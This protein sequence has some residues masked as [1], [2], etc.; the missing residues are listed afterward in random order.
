MARPPDGRVSSGLRKHMMAQKACPGNRSKRVRKSGRS[1]LAWLVGVPLVGFHMGLLAQR[2]LGTEAL[3]P[4]AVIRWLLS[5][6]LLAFLQRATFSFG[7]IRSPAVGI[8]AILVVALIHAPVAAPEQGL[9][10]AATGLGLA[11]SVGILCRTG[12]RLPS[13]LQSEP[14]ARSAISVPCLSVARATLKDRAPP[15]L[16]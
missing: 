1:A 9:P 7:S 10:I 16:N 6:A 11:L 8:A 5:L 4:V 14:I 12:G 13:L 15:V 3:D 2:A